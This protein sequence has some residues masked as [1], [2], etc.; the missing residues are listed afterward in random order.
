MVSTSSHCIY[1]PGP[2]RRVSLEYLCQVFER[3]NT[4][5]LGQICKH[6]ARIVV[7]YHHGDQSN[8]NNIKIADKLFRWLLEDVPGMHVYV[9]GQPGSWSHLVQTDVESM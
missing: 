7:L 4:Q 9:R 5:H 2:M 8:V 1:P 6:R 3:F